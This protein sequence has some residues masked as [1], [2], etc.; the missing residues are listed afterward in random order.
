MNMLQDYYSRKQ[1]SVQFICTIFGNGNMVCKT[2]AEVND[3][4][5]VIVH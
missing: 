1:I 2:W 4:Y 3:Q 5:I